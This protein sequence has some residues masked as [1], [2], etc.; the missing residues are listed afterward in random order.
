LMLQKCYCIIAITALLSL[1]I[2]LQGSLKLNQ[3]STPQQ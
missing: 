3:C 1:N 2:A